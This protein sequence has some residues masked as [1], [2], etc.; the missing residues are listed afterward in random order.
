MRREARRDV[1]LGG[2]LTNDDKLWKIADFCKNFHGRVMDFHLQALSQVIFQVIFCSFCMSCSKQCLQS[3]V[4][5]TILHFVS[6][7]KFDTEKQGRGTK[8]S[9]QLPPTS[10]GLS[11]LALQD[12]RTIAKVFQMEPISLVSYFI[13]STGIQ[14]PTPSI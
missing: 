9:Q 1:T 3:V 13:P 5:S 4:N 14:A 8:K 7:L 12:N 6:I 10:Q 11:T 2:V